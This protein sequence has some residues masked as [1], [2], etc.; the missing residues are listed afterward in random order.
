MR[1]RGTLSRLTAV[2]WILG[3]EVVDETGAFTI[4]YFAYGSKF[5]A[6]CFVLG[7]SERRTVMSEFCPTSAL[8]YIAPLIEAFLSQALTPGLV[9][10]CLVCIC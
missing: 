4:L 2:R 8:F 9:N 10:Q 1:Y 6:K 5:R 3:C 7:N